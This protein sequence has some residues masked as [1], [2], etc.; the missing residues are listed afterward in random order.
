MSYKLYKAEAKVVAYFWGKE[1]DDLSA[2]ADECVYAERTNP[3]DTEIFEVT[4]DTPIEDHW[5]DGIPYGDIGEDERTVGK[6]MASNDFGF[7]DNEDPTPEEYALLD[8]ESEYDDK[9][10]PADIWRDEL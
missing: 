3:I 7:Y 1:G 6:I 10:D 5:V 9:A 8:E 4:E 2:L